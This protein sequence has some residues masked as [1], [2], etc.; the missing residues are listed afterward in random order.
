MEQPPRPDAAMLPFDRSKLLDALRAH[1]SRP[2]EFFMAGS[3]ADQRTHPGADIDIYALTTEDANQVNPSEGEPTVVLF[4]LEGQDIDLE[5]WSRSHLAALLDRF[6]TL[7]EGRLPLITF[8]ERLLLESLR[9]ALPL[10][11]A[12]MTE[13]FCNQLERGHFRVYEVERRYQ[14]WRKSR[15]VIENLMLGEFLLPAFTELSL[16]VHSAADAYLIARG[17]YNPHRRWLFQRFDQ[18]EVPAPERKAQFI[19][20]QFPVIDQDSAGLRRTLETTVFFLDDVY[21]ELRR[22]HPA[23]VTE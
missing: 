22:F 19:R 2:A 10:E 13:R 15:R 1:V 17:N 7:A 21:A 18:L 8:K 14:D 23:A 9:I 3:L 12:P 11:A 5:I 6:T 20:H 4:V 16:A